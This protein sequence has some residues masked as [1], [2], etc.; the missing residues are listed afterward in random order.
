[1][2]HF[3]SRNSEITF[4]QDIF[5]FYKNAAPRWT[6]EMLKFSFRI[7]FK[8]G[9]WLCRFATS[10][11]APPVDEPVKA[12]DKYICTYSE[13]ENATRR[14]KYEETIKMQMAQ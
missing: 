4:G 10:L 12:V 3:K 1:M 7:S 11:I 14:D 2:K 5:P 9:C 8:P 13:R 6:I